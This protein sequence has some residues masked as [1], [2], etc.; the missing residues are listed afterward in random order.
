MFRSY[1]TCAIGIVCIMSYFHTQVIHI[2]DFLGVSYSPEEVKQRLLEDVTTFQRSKQAVNTDPYMP[3]QR[4]LI[5]E[6]LRRII[7]RLQLE[8]DGDTLGI[9]EYLDSD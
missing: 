3:E 2:L 4:E 5:R 9:E 7:A 8:N 6:V 1:T